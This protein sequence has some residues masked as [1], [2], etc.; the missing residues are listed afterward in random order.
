MSG[1]VNFDITFKS[2]AMLELKTYCNDKKEE[3]ATEYNYSQ[4]NSYLMEGGKV[5]EW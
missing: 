4:K 5:A 2:P 1:P 3:G